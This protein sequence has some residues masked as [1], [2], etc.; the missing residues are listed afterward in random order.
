[1]KIDY[2]NISKDN[3]NIFY[4]LM[5]EYYRD[6]EDSNTPQHII[7]AFIKQQFNMIV[8]DKTQGKLISVNHEIVGFIIWMIDEK[9]SD[10]SIIPGYGTILEVGLVKNFRNKGIGKIV[11]KY[12]EK[13]MFLKEV[14][15]FYVTVYNP[16][17]IFWES[18]GYIKTEKIAF[19]GL[20]IYKKVKKAKI[21]NN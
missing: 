9:S 4:D 5:L 7:D 18:C 21:D 13:Q 8:E 20:Q 16:A 11:V 2:I 10:Y 3:Y 15:N 17:K 1:M 14:N 19:N 12:A 6:G